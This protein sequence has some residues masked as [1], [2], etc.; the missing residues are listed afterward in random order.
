MHIKYRTLV[1]RL[2][3]TGYHV[4]NVRLQ[5]RK[6]R[7]VSAFSLLSRNPFN[8][9]SA[10]RNSFV[11]SLIVWPD[12]YIIRERVTSV[13][14][15]AHRSKPHAVDTLG[16]ECSGKT[17]KATGWE[18]GAIRYAGRSRLRQ[19][20]ANASVR[21]ADKFPEESFPKGEMLDVAVTR[22]Y[23]LLPRNR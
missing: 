23:A 11:P 19:S 5:C 12:C 15:V 1:A 10:Q 18:V 7:R 9:E 20:V 21:N 3:E 14:D 17:W 2:S 6:G 13:V 8:V 22:I 4:C 16:H